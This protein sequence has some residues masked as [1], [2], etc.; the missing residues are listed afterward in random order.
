MGDAALAFD[1]PGRETLLKYSLRP[2]LST[3][4]LQPGPERL[5][6]IALAPLPPSARRAVRGPFG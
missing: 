5:L 1:D 2:A 3:E 4:Q 6:R